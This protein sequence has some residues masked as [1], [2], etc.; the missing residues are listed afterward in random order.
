M[1][2]A[3][4][5]STEGH[6]NLSY[7]DSKTTKPLLVSMCNHC[8]LI[9]QNPI[10]SKAELCRYYSHDYRQ[11]YKHSF[12]PK[13][14]HVYRA[15]TTAMQRIHFLTDN[16]I[17]SGKLLDIGA[18]GGEFVYLS[19]KQGFNSKG[20]EPNIGYAE[21]ANKHYGNQI[22]AGNLDDLQGS[23]DVITLF[24]V[25][26]H[27]A[28]PIDA[29]AKLHAALN[30]NGKLLIEV[31]WIETNDASPKNI[32]FKAHLYY[33]STET[34]IACASHYFDVVKIDTQ[35]NLKIIFKAKAQ[36]TET[37]LPSP[38]SVAALKTRMKNKGWGEY[39][40]IGGGLLKPVKQLRRILKERQIKDGSPKNILDNLSLKQSFQSH[41]NNN[42]QTKAYE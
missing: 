42:L 36:L 6:E 30:P 39:L 20:L 7:Q 40:F 22:T 9:Q 35:S 10:P 19:S 37:T 17:S 3:L 24:H 14:K 31:P 16:N 33:F 2:C 8:G 23:Y 29:F 38:Q 15:G 1:K 34:L 18:G 27:L 32:Y 21:F 12:E 25:L 11:D 26:E 28:S 41:D 4:C 13:P 5:S